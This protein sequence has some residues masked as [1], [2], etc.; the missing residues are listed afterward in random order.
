MAKDFMAL[1][2]PS[3]QT[4]PIVRQG[5]LVYLTPTVIP[6]SAYSGPRTEL[7]ISSLMD[8]LDLETIDLEL[9]GI[10]DSTHCE[11]D[12]LSK[13]SSLVAMAQARARSKPAFAR[14]VAAKRKAT[15]NMDYW[16]IDDPNC[17]LIR[18][19]VKTRRAMFGLT[20]LRSSLPVA[21]AR[22]RA[23]LSRCRLEHSQWGGSG[24]A[25]KAMHLAD[26]C[27]RVCVSRRFLAVR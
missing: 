11:Y 17:L 18:H 26:A 8:D 12:H 16:E 20:R 15:K 22:Y 7:E 13:I 27:V 19:N 10:T 14:T 3:N 23:G 4:V 21:E 9:R 2:T 6:Y 24:G 25:K 1:M 5:T